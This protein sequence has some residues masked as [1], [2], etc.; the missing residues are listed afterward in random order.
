[1]GVRWSS[2]IHI[3]QFHISISVFP[4]SLGNNEFSILENRYSGIR[5]DNHEILLWVELQFLKNYFN[6]FTT[7][8]TMFSSQKLKILIICYDTWL[9]WS[10]KI[11]PLVINFILD[12]TWVNLFLRGWILEEAMWKGQ[13]KGNFIFPHLGYILSRDY[14]GRSIQIWR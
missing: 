12:M 3:S 4:F 2:N 14:S 10:E 6:S 8:F 9:L 13:R 5:I 11:E 1:M 7:R